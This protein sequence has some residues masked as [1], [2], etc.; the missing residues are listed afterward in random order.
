MFR[1]CCS[2]QPSL[3]QHLLQSIS[4]VFSEEILHSGVSMACISA[5]VQDLFEGRVHMRHVT[6]KIHGQQ[7]NIDR[8][9]DRFVDFLEQRQF[10]GT[11][12]SCS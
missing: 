12:L 8:F 11:L 7:A 9:D 2:R 4:E 5:D 3:P 1:K 10:G 6:I